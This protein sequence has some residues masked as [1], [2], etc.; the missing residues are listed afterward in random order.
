M[1]GY[2]RSRRWA[3]GR[4]PGHP[5]RRPARATWSG[6]PWRSRSPRGPPRR[7]ERSSGASDGDAV[8]GRGHP[9]LVE[10]DERRSLLVF[11]R[12]LSHRAQREREREQLYR[13]QAAR[14]GGRA[15][16]R[17]GPRAPDAAG[18]RAGP[19]PP[20]ADPRAA[21]AAPVR[22]ALGRGGHDLPGRTRTPGSWS[23]APRPAGSPTSRS[24]RR[25]RHIAARVARSRSPLLVN[26]PPDDDLAAPAMRGMASVISVPLT[27]GEDVTGVIQV[28]VPAPR[29]ST[30][31]TCCCSAW[32]PTAWRWRSTT[33]WSSSA[34]TGSPRRSSAACCPSG[35][36]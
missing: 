3:E 26:N 32:P 15:H 29:S 10:V 20:R 25:D 17:H 34:S 31:T 14:A 23:C 22:G 33:R 30:T 9:A 8:F 13:E 4:R 1:F 12:D 36:P 19:R 16:G 28:G 11:V 24:W 21:R 2:G 18:R 35:C 6:W 27:A 7:S 5:A